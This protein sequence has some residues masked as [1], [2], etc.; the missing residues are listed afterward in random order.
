MIIDYAKVYFSGPMV[1]CNERNSDGSRPSKDVEWHEI[2]AQLGGTTLSVWDMKAVEEA[3]Q[4]GGQ[5]PPSYINVTD[6]VRQ[7]YSTYLASY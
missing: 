6:A 4:R 5:S 1:R 3:N 2:W 7:P